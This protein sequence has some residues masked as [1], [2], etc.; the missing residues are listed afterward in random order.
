MT[1]PVVGLHGYLLKS[2]RAELRLPNPWSPGDTGVLK[3]IA[4]REVSMTTES[5]YSQHYMYL[6]NQ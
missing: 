6:Q 4:S 2:V 1:T 5:S 3:G